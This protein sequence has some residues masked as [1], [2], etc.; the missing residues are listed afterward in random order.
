M[1]KNIL[2]DLKFN[3]ISYLLEVIETGN[4]RKKVDTYNKL[5]KMK[6]NEESG[7]IIID[8]VS[9]LKQKSSDDFNIELSLLSLLFKNYYDSYSLHL[10]EIFK[11]LNTDTKYEILN[12]LSSSN[13]PSEIVLYRSLV[14]NYYEELKNIPIGNISSNKDNYELI[15]PELFDTFKKTNNRNNLLLVLS[16]FIN[17]G[18]VPIVHIKKYKTIIQKQI[19]SIFKEGIKYKFNSKENFMGNKE[20]IDL[21][22]FL[23][24]A[25][26]IEYYVSNKETKSYLDKLF[27]TKDNQLKL[28]I[29]ENYVR[30]EKDISKIN[31]NSMAK[32]N[33]S[34]YPLYSFLTYSNLQ[35]L[36]PKKYCLNK[37]LALSDLFLNFSISCGYSKVPYDFKLEEVK[38]IDGFKYFIYKFKTEFNYN[39]EVIDPATDYLLKNIKI[40]KELINNAET[41]YLGFSGGYSKDEPSL[42]SKEVNEAKFIKLDDTYEKVLDKLL[43]SKI[44]VKEEKIIKKEKEIVKQKEI[45]EEKPSKLASIINF[46]RIFTFISLIII[47]LF[48]VLV[49]YVSNVDL[50]GL[51]K[52]SLNKTDIIRA[53]LLKPKDLFEEISY[54]DI[55]N[56][57]ESEYYVLFFKKKDKSTYYEFLNILLKN[58]YKIY[59]VDLSNKDNKPI[60]SGNETG[61]TISG[62]TL[63]KIKDRE[64]SFYINGKANIINEFKSYTDEIKKKEAEAKLE[65]EKE[66]A[67]KKK[68]E[69]KKKEEQTKKKKS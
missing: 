65:K 6:I 40:D 23:E 9:S 8:K 7:H 57:E 28:F 59:Y 64:Y 4:F 2:K 52:H 10:I 41:T 14:L 19:L 32:D 60:Y 30:K 33:L 49:L 34:R 63:L 51:R 1:F 37:E 67:E 25:I 15:F 54:R 36:M 68:A 58:E 55:F 20:Y 13:E 50:F 22:V 26:N 38:I 42:I 62:D 43:I 35:K 31:L 47:L 27:K 18:V 56:R 11:K 17:Q 45:K 44:G 5:Q 16:D 69:E 46:S 48:I 29:L 24:V 12:I 3:R 39:E 53:V 21:R 61:F 66:E